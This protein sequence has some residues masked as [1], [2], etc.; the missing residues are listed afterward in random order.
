VDVSWLVDHLLAGSECLLVDVR[1]AHK[2]VQGHVDGA[3]NLTC[4]NLMMRRLR[5]GNLSLSVLVHGEDAKAKFE[6]KMKRRYVVLY[7]H[8]Q[9][10]SELLVLI[11]KRLEHECSSQIKVLEGGFSK[12]SSSYP[13]LCSKLTDVD[14]VSAPSR[15]SLAPLTLSSLS[16]SSSDDQEERRKRHDGA[17]PVQI[18]PHLFLG[19]ER[20]SSDYELLERLG[21]THVLNVTANVENKFE[22]RFHYKRIPIHDNWTQDI[23]SHFDEAIAFIGELFAVDL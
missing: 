14:G 4:S 6:E 5:K 8:D 22:D 23:S 2:F 18:R 16:I 3:V 7:D 15:N 10:T 17:E 12:F 20:N 1:P 19:S 13:H 21:I 9:G 11:T